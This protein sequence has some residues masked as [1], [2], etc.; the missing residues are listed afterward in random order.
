MKE[1]KPVRTVSP[2][3]LR[4]CCR[5]PL[6]LDPS[7]QKLFRSTDIPADIR[8]TPTLNPSGDEIEIR[9]DN[10]IPG[11][12]SDHVTRLPWPK[13]VPQDMIR[14]RMARTIV[15]QFTTHPV[16]WNR[17]KLH[18][19]PDKWVEYNDYMTSDDALYK[20]LKHL[21]KWGILF[22]RNVPDSE[23]SVEHIANRIGCLKETLYGRTWDVK[24]KPSAENIAYTS[25]YLGLHQDLLYTTCPPKLQILHSLRA[26]APGGESLFSDPQQAVKDLW[27]TNPFH[28]SPPFQG[29]INPSGTMSV[30]MDLEYF[31]DHLRIFTNEVEKE[32]NVY[33]LRLKEGECVIFDNERI[34]HARREFDAQKG[35][36]WLKG[37][38]VD[39][40]VFESKLQTLVARFESPAKQHVDSLFPDFDLAQ[41]KRDLTRLRRNFVR[42][43]EREK[44]E[45]RKEEDEDEFDEE[46]MEYDSGSVRI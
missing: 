3:F 38:Y 39:R 6:C 16:I 27:E 4:D 37:A 30:D 28:Y 43:T 32:K 46:D 42:P 22:L 2:I 5:C 34:L 36:R 33:E 19:D 21:L 14:H 41:L 23:Q 9:W 11:F 10:D 45:E 7:G 35:E 31:M 26:Q 8:G 20:S 24:S 29:V 40:D 17:V 13:L 44:E 12:P 25:H 1:E 15:D 18:K